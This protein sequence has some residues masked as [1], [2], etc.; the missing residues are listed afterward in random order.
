MTH[1]GIAARAQRDAAG[2]DPLAALYD[3][4]SDVGL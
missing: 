2:F 1:T 3:L 4:L